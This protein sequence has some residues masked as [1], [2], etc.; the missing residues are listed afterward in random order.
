MPSYMDWSVDNFTHAANLAAKQ[1]IL[2]FTWVYKVNQG[3]MFSASFSLMQFS[4]HCAKPT[5]VRQRKWCEHWYFSVSCEHMK[6]CQ[7]EHCMKLTRVV[8]LAVNNF[9]NL[10]G[11]CLSVFTESLHWSHDTIKS[12]MTKTNLHV[13]SERG[14]NNGIWGNLISLAYHTTDLT[15][16]TYEVDLGVELCRTLLRSCHN[17]WGS[18]EP[19]VCCSKTHLLGVFVVRLRTF[20]CASF[21]Q[22][23][24]WWIMEHNV[25]GLRSM[26]ETSNPTVPKP[27]VKP[28]PT[29]PDVPHKKPAQRSGGRPPAVPPKQDAFS[30]ETKIVVLYE[31]KE[32]PQKFRTL[33]GKRYII[34]RPPEMTGPPPKKPPKPVFGGCLSRLTSLSPLFHTKAVVRLFLV[35]ALQASCCWIFP[36]EG[37]DEQYSDVDD[38]APENV[39]E[40]VK[41]LASWTLYSYIYSQMTTWQIFLFCLHVPVSDIFF[42]FFF[43]KLLIFHVP[44]HI[45]AEV[46]WTVS[47]VQ[48]CTQHTYILLVLRV[49]LMRLTER[50][51]ESCIHSKHGYMD[52]IWLTKWNHWSWTARF[53]QKHRF[54]LL[55]LTQLQIFNFIF[56]IHQDFFTC[57]HRQEFNA[58]HAARTC[59]YQTGPSAARAGVRA[60]VS[61]RPKQSKSGVVGRGSRITQKSGKSEGP[62]KVVKSQSYEWWGWDGGGGRTRNPEKWEG[63]QKRRSPKWLWSGLGGGHRIIWPGNS[64]GLQKLT[65]PKRFGWCWEGARGENPESRKVCKNG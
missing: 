20:S 45:R 57:E 4:R 52:F 39:T 37:S 17:S 26:F 61:I 27:A 21:E 24:I 59:T 15:S 16:S 55:N 2:R 3:P 50:R 36:D 12:H 35:A 40:W 46:D 18:S 6:T 65:K 10:F 5:P 7:L 29:K 64:E 56:Q 30:K 32:L 31:G 60:W 47:E 8:G 1:K 51:I 11:E 9:Q 19:Q 44:S 28:K 43:L 13:N 58:V 53:H 22:P 25:K 54:R 48:V 33:D 38:V 42:S 62:Q 14:S 49:P 23:W 63:L 41:I 34:Q